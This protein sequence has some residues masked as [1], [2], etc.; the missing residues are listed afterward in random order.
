MTPT[1][2]ALIVAQKLD[3]ITGLILADGATPG[4]NLFASPVLP[5]EVSGT[6]VPNAAVFVRASGGAPPVPN[7]GSAGASSTW[8]PRVQVIVRGDVNGEDTARALANLIRETLHR[9]T[10][11][12]YVSCLVVDSSPI[13]LGK[14]TGGHP[15]FSLNVELWYTAP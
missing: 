7:M 3:T 8:Y 14:D 1:E 10:L 9:A 11:T 13:E 2:P 15:L 12:G 4:A 5:A 6:G